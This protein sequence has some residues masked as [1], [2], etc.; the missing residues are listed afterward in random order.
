M[1][2]ILF[3]LAAF[4]SA[5]AFP[6]F[7]EY[8]RFGIPDS[9]EIR[10]GL[11]ETWFEAPFSA[12]RTSVPEVRRNSTGTEF[13]IRA[14]ESD[15]D[16]SIFVAPRTTIS[17][18]VTSDTGSYTEQ[19]TVYPG[20]ASGSWMLVRN[21]RNGKPLRIRFYF[22]KNSEV[23][24]QFSPHGKTAL[25]DLVVFGAYAAKGVPTGVPFSSFYTAPFEDVV[26]I[27]ADTIPWN[28]V[29]PDTDMYHSIK[30]MAAVIDGAIPDIVYADN[31]MY[32]GDGNLVRISDGKPFDRSDFPEGKYILSSAGFV[33][34][35][36]DG[37]V[38]PLAGGRIRR[39]PLAVKT[40][41][42][43]ETGYQG[44]LSQVYDLYFSLNW[45]R[46]LASAVIS[47]YTGKKYMFNE[48]GVDVTAEPFSVGLTGRG[49]ENTVTF[50]ENNGYDVA[51]IK[52]LLYVL[53]ASDPGTFYF[54]AIRGTDR[55]VTP[56]VK[57]FNECA[58]IFPYFEN[59]GGFSCRVFMN[60]KSLPLE[61][62]CS[63]Y[64]DSS[65]YLTKVRSSDRFF[66]E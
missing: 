33:K 49:A 35:I 46:N 42:I 7:A 51:R 38:M 14:E 31:A 12:V 6:A 40:V 58:A 30:Q 57:A 4:F 11:V 39:A 5:A 16:F 56:E 53:A 26:R 22:A 20:D 15:D 32:D 25:C 48:S 36:A 9:S 29:R 66:P 13:Q 23:Y 64:S 47:V 60:G 3:F 44:V 17:V 55:S 45:I 62:F 21:K 34:W 1:R 41:E 59:D 37:L 24:I 27:T 2:R 19:H 52:P 10:D 18:E 65:V 28:F 63:L 50:I 8:N 54:G 61:E 43:K